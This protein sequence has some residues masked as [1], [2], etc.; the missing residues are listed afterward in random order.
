MTRARKIIFIVLITFIFV[1]GYMTWHKYTMNQ[2]SRSPSQELP[3]VIQSINKD[4]YIGVISVN[5]NG[6]NVYASE[7]YN[8]RF[9]YP[10]GWRVG[11]NHLGYGTF[12]LFNFRSELYQK[13]FQKGQNKIEAGI[14][15][16]NT[17]GTSSDYPEKTRV[18]KDVV[19]SGKLATR[20]EIELMGGEKILSYIT[21]L[22]NFSNKY[23]GITIYGDPL[24]F[25]VLDDL[26]KSIEWLN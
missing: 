11:D 24:N 3:S 19:V 20:F 16:G 17:Y 21:A 5:K 13:G 8:L 22:P 10:Q 6:Q 9:T 7:K 18:A 26:V 25:Y 12:Q 1:S 23:L 14:G 4:E 2:T 15:S